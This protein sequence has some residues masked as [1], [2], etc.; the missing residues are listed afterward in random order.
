MK[1]DAVTAEAL[2]EAAI[3]HVRHMLSELLRTLSAQSVPASYHQTL[4]DADK[5]IESVMKL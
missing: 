4:M 3:A 1:S 5:L 2:R